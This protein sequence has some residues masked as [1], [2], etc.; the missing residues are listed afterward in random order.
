[1]EMVPEG[2]PA[3][4]STSQVEAPMEVMTGGR[5]ESMEQSGPVKVPVQA[6]TLLEHVP[7]PLQT[8]VLAEGQKTDRLVFCWV[9]KVAHCD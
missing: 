9:A 5:V 7:W 1:M 6:Q 4:P 2:Q 8:W 3:R